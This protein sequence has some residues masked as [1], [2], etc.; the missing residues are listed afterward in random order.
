VRHRIVCLV[1]SSVFCNGSICLP[2]SSCFFVLAK[3]KI[4]PHNNTP[5]N[6]RPHW[7]RVGLS[8][9]IWNN[10]II[11]RSVG[12]KIHWW[13]KKNTYVVDDARLCFRYQ[14]VALIC[15]QFSSDWTIFDVWKITLTITG[16]HVPIHINYQERRCNWRKL[17]IKPFR[18]YRVILC[19]HWLTR[20]LK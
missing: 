6:L 1:E 3:I 20:Y 17:A 14:S 5:Y 11:E 16:Y 10:H 8:D 15:R 2:L 7:A 12:G 19:N 4:M 13:S 18:H 9:V